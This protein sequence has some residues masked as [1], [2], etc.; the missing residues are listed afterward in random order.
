MRGLTMALAVSGALAV[1]ACSGLDTTQQRTLT[2]TA[3]GAAIGAVAGA[4]GGNMA[5][6][7]LVGAGAGALGGYVYDQHEKA[8]GGS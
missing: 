7:G 2:G 8:N 3:G 1:S 5:L 4:I 6:G